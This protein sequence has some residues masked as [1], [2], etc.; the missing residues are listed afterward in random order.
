[1]SIHQSINLLIRIFHQDQPVISHFHQIKKER[2]QKNI[3]S[4]TNP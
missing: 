2:C 1:M 3:N 4:L